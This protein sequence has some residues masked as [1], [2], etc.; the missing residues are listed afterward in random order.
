MTT[1]RHHDPITDGFYPAKIAM[2]HNHRHGEE[3]EVHW[4]VMVDFG[5]DKSD[6]SF[7]D[8]PT[9]YLEEIGANMSELGIA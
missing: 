7:V 8:L 5:V 1:I 6:I 4:R 9:E 2:P 3:C